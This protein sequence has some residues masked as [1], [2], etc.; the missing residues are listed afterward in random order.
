[1]IWRERENRASWINIDFFYNLSFSFHFENHLR[2][3]LSSRRYHDFLFE[4]KIANSE[5]LL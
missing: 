5:T 2:F 1:M 4:I 3:Y